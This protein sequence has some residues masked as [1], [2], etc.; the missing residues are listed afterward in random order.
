MLIGKRAFLPIALCAL[1]CGCEHPAANR[2]SA[3]SRGPTSGVSYIGYEYEGVVPD[4]TLPNGVLVSGGALIGDVGASSYGLSLVSHGLA[5]MLWLEHAIGGTNRH[6]HWRVDAAL[7]LP[8]LPH[9]QALVWGALCSIN[10]TNDSEIIAAVVHTDTERY[11]QVVRAWR[12]DR[13]QHTFRGMD[14]SGISRENEGY[15]ADDSE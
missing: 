10:G 8:V 14:T 1:V 5:S 9:G 3:V 2:L 13:Q 12:A 6:I 15:G 11:T 4:D 7:D